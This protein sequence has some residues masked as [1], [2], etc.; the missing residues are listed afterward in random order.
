MRDGFVHGVVLSVNIG[1]GDW[2]VGVSDRLSLVVDC[3]LRGFAFGLT[4]AAL[5]LNEPAERTGGENDAADA[6]S[7]V[8]WDGLDVS[9]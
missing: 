7:H 8:E 5:V 6:Q 1:D 4:D 9:K 3:D 2:R